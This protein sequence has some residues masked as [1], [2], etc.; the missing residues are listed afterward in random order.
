MHDNTTLNSKGKFALTGKHKKKNAT[1]QPS[2][3][4]GCHWLVMMPQRQHVVNVFK[5]LLLCDNPKKELGFAVY[6]SEFHGESIHFDLIYEKK[7]QHT[8]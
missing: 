6:Y 5:H 4:P 2:I 3:I 8:L 1:D 7:S